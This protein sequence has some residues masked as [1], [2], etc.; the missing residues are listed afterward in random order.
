MQQLKARVKQEPA[1]PL[2]DNEGLE[3]RLIDALPFALTGAQRR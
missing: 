3:A 2:L 1:A